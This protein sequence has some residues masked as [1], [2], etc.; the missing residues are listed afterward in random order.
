[1]SGLVLLLIGAAN[2]FGIPQGQEVIVFSRTAALFQLCTHAQTND[3]KRSR[4]CVAMLG[5][6]LFLSLPA[7][8]EVHISWRGIPQK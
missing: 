5:L 1:M 7:V 8:V 2:I 3:M 4:Y 6:L